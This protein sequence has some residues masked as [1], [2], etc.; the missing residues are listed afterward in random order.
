MDD[1]GG[2]LSI[3]NDDCVALLFRAVEKLWLK[4]KL[5]TELKIELN[6]V[7]ETGS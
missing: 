4:A 6:T 1:L 2:D 5:K 7:E 3:L